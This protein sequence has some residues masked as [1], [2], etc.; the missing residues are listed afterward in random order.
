MSPT[1]IFCRV[2]KDAKKTL[3]GRGGFDLAQA[4]LSC[5]VGTIHLAPSPLKKP[6]THK[7]TQRGA[8]AP[9]WILPASPLVSCLLLTNSQGAA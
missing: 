3:K 4:T 5:P 8:Q 1:G 6:L 9:L 7:T 2:T